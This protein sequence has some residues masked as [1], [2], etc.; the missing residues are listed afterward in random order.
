MLKIQNVKLIKSYDFDKCVQETYGKPY[1]LQQQDDCMPRGIVYITAREPHLNPDDYKNDTIPEEINGEEKGVSFKAWLA[2]DPKQPFSS[3]REDI[4]LWWERNF[5][6]SLE[7][8]VNDLYLKGLIP[9]GE[10]V[11]N[12]DW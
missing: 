7:M 1:I 8:V 4:T 5:Y 2:R 11:I 3:G 12:I 10:Y 6:P 9:E